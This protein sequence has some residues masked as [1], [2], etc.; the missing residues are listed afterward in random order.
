MGMKPYVIRQGDYLTKLAHLSGFD[1]DSVWSDPKNAELRSSRPDPSMLRPGDVLFVPDEPKRPLR[2]NPKEN[3][4]F[5]ARVPTVKV[6]VVV[7]SDDEPIRDEPYVVL[8]IGDESPKKTD[9]E[10]RVEVEVPVH[11]R[12]VLVRFVDRKTEMRI[13]IGDL[14][15]PDTPTGVRM[16]LA[17]LGYHADKVEGADRSIAHDD[18]ALQGA[19]VAFQRANGLEA[20]GEVD[21]ATRAALVEAHGS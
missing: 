14:D 13:A 7:C 19:V 5:V 17:S 3:N 15:P 1:A 4:V 8:G 21:D 20:T 6:S 11:V 9:G 10:G 12:E 2:L 18:D 16:R